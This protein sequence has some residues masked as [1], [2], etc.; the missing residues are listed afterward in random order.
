M[1]NCFLTWLLFLGFTAIS[2]AQD[3]K[4]TYYF[5]STTPQQAPLPAPVDS[6]STVQDST[7]EEAESS[8]RGDLD[9][10]KYEIL[11]LRKEMTGLRSEISNVQ[12]NLAKAHKKHTTGALILAAGIGAYIFGN[13]SAS[14]HTGQ[15]TQ[16]DIVLI[17][18]GFGATV[19]GSILMITSHNYI[20]KAGKP[21]SKYR[22]SNYSR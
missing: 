11:N 6:L 8:V 5:K 7:K 4:N 10:L 12:L 3:N 19:T 2:F 22:R 16:Q 18:G 20:G 1:H 13:I 17:L 14:S 9:S 15:L 21:L